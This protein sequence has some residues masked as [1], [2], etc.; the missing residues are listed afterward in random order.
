ML[1]FILWS[2]LF[3]D[4]KGRAVFFST[5]L[6]QF[7]QVFFLVL[8]HWLWL[9]SS[10]HRLEMKLNIEVFVLLY[11]LTS[12]PRE[13]TIELICDEDWLFVKLLKFDK[14][15]LNPGQVKGLFD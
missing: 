5:E 9:G 12:Y 15:A 1:F 2:N 3:V 13:M 7:V 14:G 6:Y 11:H 8:S 10:N 4:F